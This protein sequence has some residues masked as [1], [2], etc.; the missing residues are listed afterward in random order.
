MNFSL[1]KLSF[2]YDLLLQECV[3]QDVM[4]SYLHSL[5]DLYAH[6]ELRWLYLHKVK[7]CKCH[8][9]K[10]FKQ[11]ETV[12]KEVHNKLLK[13][14]AKLEQHSISLEIALQQCQEQMKNYT[15]CKE[16]AS[17]VFLKEREQYFEIQD[18]KAQLQNKN[19]AISELKKLIEKCK[20]KSVETKIDKPTPVRQ[21]NALKIPKPLVLGTPTIFSDSLKRK[22]FSKTKPVTKTNVSE[23]LSKPFTTQNLH[24]TASQAVR[25]TNVIKPGMYRIDTRPTQTRSPQLPQTFSNTNP[26]V[27]TSTRVIHKTSVSRPYL[28]S[29]QMKDKVM[30]NNSQVKSKKTGVEDHHRI[31]SISN[32]TKSVPTCNDSLKSKTSN[33]NVVYATCEKCVFNS[34]HDACV[35]KFL[36]YVNARSK[37]PQAVPIRTRKPIRKANKSVA[38]PPKK[39]VASD[40]II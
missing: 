34:N 23:G 24:Q 11:T 32:K 37:K 20:G 2:L 16:K 9:Q 13:S 38:T 21:T 40:S 1:T 4:C 6:T 25:N 33:I 35:S 19:I 15:I 28:K 17:T 26:R 3:P 12:S 7:E 14:F 8:A 18:L 29:T 27:S 30:Q 10:L 39:K 31:S 36:D 5:S 22:N